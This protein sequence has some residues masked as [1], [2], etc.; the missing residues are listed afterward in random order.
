M[1]IMLVSALKLAP[2]ILQIITPLTA[3]SLVA[4]WI[5]VLAESFSSFTKA[6]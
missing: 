3:W 5:A 4:M 6:T 2:L 1:E